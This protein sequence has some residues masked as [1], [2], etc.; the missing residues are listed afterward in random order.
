[1]VVGAGFDTL[2]LRI[3]ERFP[4]VQCFE[5]DHPATQRVKRTA[6][7]S[8]RIDR[9]NLHLVALDLA[10]SSVS[11]ALARAPEWR[12]DVATVVTAEGILCYLDE[13]DVTRVLDGVREATA[14]GSTLLLTYMRTDDKGEIV[15]GKNARLMRAALRLVGEPVNWAIRREALAAFLC[16]RGYT[17]DRSPTPEQLRVHYL[18]PV[19]LG[20]AIVGDIELMAVARVA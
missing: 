10:S 5:I 16:A 20:D 11:A 9:S 19:G 12:N 1:L 17:L 2:S 18:E 6:V 4:D 15:Y 3:A 8:L 14:S 13:G 7:E